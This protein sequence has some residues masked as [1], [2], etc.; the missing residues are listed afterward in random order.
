MESSI[1]GLINNTVVQNAFKDFDS[2]IKDV[3]KVHHYTSVPGL[4]N[5]LESGV[6]RFSNINSQNDPR[7]I[8]FG[9]K[10]IR[11]IIEDKFGL[12][13]KILKQIDDHK[14]TMKDQ[15]A[16]ILN[17]I[18]IFSTSTEK[19]SYQQWINYSDSGAGLSLAFD[20]ERLFT[21][22]NNKMSGK[23]FFYT[24]PIQYY[25]E[26]KNNS[27]YKNVSDFEIKSFEEIVAKLI[28]DLF[29]KKN[30]NSDNIESERYI[31]LILLA[32]LI[33]DKFHKDEKE[34][35][36]L[37]FSP[38]TKGT[39]PKEILDANDIDIV[40]S[41]KKISV[42]RKLRFTSKSRC[43]NQANEIK[44][45]SKD[46]SIIEG[47]ILGPKNTKDYILKDNIKMLMQKY[48]VNFKDID[49]SKGIIK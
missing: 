31:L 7:E 16:E 40:L 29:N 13:S 11:W 35:R 49:F 39:K 12:E 18:F 4:F 44:S 5:I 37:V 22:I 28:D 45:R 36:Y 48:N 17:N 38:I 43:V 27:D 21:T 26:D 24:Y 46:Y 41:G 19:D 14:K 32:S 47:I 3:K 23:I 2:N 6:I 34:I 15:Y 9:L 8:E 1:F 20:R 33:K 30:I 25:Y 42:I 10:V